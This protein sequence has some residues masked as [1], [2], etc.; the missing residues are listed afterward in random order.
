MVELYS[1][2]TLPGTERQQAIARLTFVHL[3]HLGII[4]EI[5]AITFSQCYNNVSI[6]ELAAL[7]IV[8]VLVS[9]LLAEFCNPD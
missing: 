2:T 3:C 1:V 7:P 4:E 9:S 6:V 5:T 8:V